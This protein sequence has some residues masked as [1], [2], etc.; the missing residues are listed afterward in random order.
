M[1]RG[2]SRP[3]RIAGP[4]LGTP[5]RRAGPLIRASPIWQR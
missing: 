3:V 1:D 2:S 5:Q 4:V